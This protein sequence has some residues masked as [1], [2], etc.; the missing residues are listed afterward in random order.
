MVVFRTFSFNVHSARDNSVG[1]TFRI[2]VQKD[3]LP[4]MSSSTL[5]R[6]LGKCSLEVHFPISFETGAFLRCSPHCTHLLW[7]ASLENGLGFLCT[8]SPAL[9]KIRWNILTL[10]L[11]ADLVL[12][13]CFSVY[14]TRML[15]TGCSRNTFPTPGL[16]LYGDDWKDILNLLLP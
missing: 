8:L 9:Y 6:L 1:E 2:F 10:S 3:G 12:S 5:R 14:C 16:V 15:G 13:L 11:F 7:A 4:Y